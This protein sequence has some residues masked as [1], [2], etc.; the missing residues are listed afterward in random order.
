MSLVTPAPSG[1]TSNASAAEMTPVF[2]FLS[3]AR[4]TPAESSAT[5]FFAP[6]A[7]PQASAAVRLASVER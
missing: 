6:E 4:M 3:A 2:P 7:A 1:T 5:S